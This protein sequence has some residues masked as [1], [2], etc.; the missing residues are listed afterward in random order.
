VKYEMSGTIL[1][2]IPQ[3]REEQT[4]CDL[5]GKMEVVGG[6][7]S[8]INAGMTWEEGKRSCVG[9]EFRPHKEQP[10]PIR[11]AQASPLPRR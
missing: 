11:P 6:Y 1:T 9:I 8:I 4:L 10:N 2:I 7:G 3:T 5:L